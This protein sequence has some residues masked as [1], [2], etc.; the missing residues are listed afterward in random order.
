MKEKCLPAEYSAEDVP[1]STGK[2][3]P[4]PVHPIPI[5]VKN[6]EAI[7]YAA[8][9]RELNTVTSAVFSPAAV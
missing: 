7:T 1:T 5:V 8:A 3:I 4:V 6:A 2:K 9:I